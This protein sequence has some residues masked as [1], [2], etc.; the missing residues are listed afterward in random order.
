M[1]DPIAVAESHMPEARRL[2]QELLT[3]ANKAITDLVLQLNTKGG[4]VEK[5]AE[6]LREAKLIRV[7]ILQT[8]ERANIKGVVDQLQGLAAEAAFDVASDTEAGP[9]FSGA[10][11]QNLERVATRPLLEIPPAWQKAADHVASLVVLATNTGA[12]IKDVLGEVSRTLQVTAKQAETLG[13]T[14]IAGA[15]RAALVEQSESANEFLAGEDY[16]VYLYDGPDEDDKTRD[17]C[18]RLVGQC[19]TRE[20][21]DGIKA[22]KGQP[23]PVWVHC[24]GYNCRHEWTP[25][26][27]REAKAQGLTIH[28]LVD[29][30][31]KPK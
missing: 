12:S 14:A 1:V 17:F 9:A 18:A 6:A 15:A 22:A 19:Y 23:T 11:L 8:M 16:F 28:G 31:K 2:L 26:T 29:V 4:L 27:V 10:S 3:A 30:P 25:I 24:G 7:Q 21:I 20:A 5:D 13:N